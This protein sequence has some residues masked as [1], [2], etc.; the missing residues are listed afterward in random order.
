MQALGDVL[1]ER[2]GN[3]LVRRVFRQVDGDQQLLSLCVDIANI[4]TTLVGEEN[5]V[6]L[7]WW[8]SNVLV[9]HNFSS[10]RANCVYQIGKR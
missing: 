1:E 5:P 3:L 6:A 10:H 9:L 4:N 7:W 2:R 8:K